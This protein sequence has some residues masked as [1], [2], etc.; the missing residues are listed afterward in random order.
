MT[1]QLGEVAATPKLFAAI[2]NQIAR[3]AMPP[4]VVVGRMPA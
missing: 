1:F 4:P 3:L 2:L